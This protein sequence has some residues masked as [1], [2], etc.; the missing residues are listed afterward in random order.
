MSSTLHSFHLTASTVDFSLVPGLM[1]AW[2]LIWLITGIKV[3][4]NMLN[5]TLSQAKMSGVCKIVCLLLVRYRTPT[6]Q[7]YIGYLLTKG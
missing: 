4:V 5:G 1:M 6:F 7:T 2:S 3:S